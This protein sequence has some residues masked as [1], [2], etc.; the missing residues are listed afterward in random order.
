MTSSNWLNRSAL[1]LDN[2][3][4]IAVCM[5]LPAIVVI[6]IMYIRFKQYLEC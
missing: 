5:S 2:R 1:V 6:T 3:Q 4:T